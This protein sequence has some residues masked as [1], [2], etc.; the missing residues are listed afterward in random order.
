MRV[1]VVTIEVKFF[2]GAQDG[3]H[4][5]LPEDWDADDP[6]QM[7]WLTTEY[8]HR[9]VSSYL[10]HLQ[11]PGAAY[12]FAGDQRDP[13]EPWYTTELH[14]EREVRADLHSS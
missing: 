10:A 7:L 1:T 13:A 4:F 5:P 12:R 2:G 8:D 3:H 11:A 9:G 6:P 14:Y